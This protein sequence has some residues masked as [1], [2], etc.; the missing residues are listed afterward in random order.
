MP[1][2]Y[3]LV[4]KLKTDNIST[5]MQKLALSYAKSYNL[6][7]DQNGHLFQGPFQRVHVKDLNYLLH[8]SR[9]VHLNPVKAE[10][11]NKAEDWNY[12]S[13]QE[14]I[15]LRDIELIQPEI[16]LDLVMVELGARMKTKQH[17][18]KKYVEMWEF[19]YMDFRLKR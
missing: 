7:Y 11:V 15:G 6:V 1:N 17:V 4:L 16:V 18:Y 19:E 13:Y 2:H 8:L 14:F 5:A 3:H 9:Y 12:S 10:I